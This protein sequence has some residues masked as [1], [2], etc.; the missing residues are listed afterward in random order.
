MNKKD[1]VS[2][3]AD[4]AG[5]LQKDAEKF[6]NAFISVV[7]DTLQKGDNVTLIG[8]GQFFVADKAASRGRD[9]KTGKIVEIPASKVVKFKVGKGLKDAVA[10]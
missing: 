3:I 2:K 7:Q 4:E 5:L 10:D 6:L 8:F 9:F 1:L